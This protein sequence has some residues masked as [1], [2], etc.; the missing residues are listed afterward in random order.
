MHR[1]KAERPFHGV[2]V[3]RTV[4]AVFNTG[5]SGGLDTSSE[6]ASDTHTD[7]GGR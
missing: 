3:G 2:S 7:N 1:E 5:Y 6:M 4:C